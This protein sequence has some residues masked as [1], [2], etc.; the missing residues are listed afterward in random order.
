MYTEVWLGVWQSRQVQSASWAS[1]IIAS[2]YRSLCND[3]QY[4]LEPSHLYTHMYISGQS[5]YLCR[6][7]YRDFWYSA[8]LYVSLYKRHACFSTVLSVNH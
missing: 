7:R 1:I 2:D 8:D 3:Q 5:L 4:D 6:Y